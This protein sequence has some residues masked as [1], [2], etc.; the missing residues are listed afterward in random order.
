[1]IDLCEGLIIDQLVAVASCVAASVRYS[2]VPWLL[3]GHFWKKQGSSVHSA[4]HS[5]TGSQHIPLYGCFISS[6]FSAHC[7]IYID[8]KV[9]KIFK[10][11]FDLL[12]QWCILRTSFIFNCKIHFLCIF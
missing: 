10:E 5:F 6:A 7:A 1:M 2:S 8:K 12:I 4:V 11:M 9:K 3:C